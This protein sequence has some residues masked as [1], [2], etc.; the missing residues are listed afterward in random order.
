MTLQEKA[1]STGRYF[2]GSQTVNDSL[3]IGKFTFVDGDC[4]LTSGA[5]MLVVTGTLTIRGN[6]DFRGVI[7]VLGK[8]EVI[9]NGGGNGGIFG[10]VTIAAFNRTA[11]GFT[12]PTFNTNGGGN[13]TIQ[14]DSAALTTAFGSGSNVTGIREF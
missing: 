11:G 6:T 2:S 3:N 9:R 13:S 10:G 5:G 7:L 14:Y 1:K 4:T 12:A 8:G